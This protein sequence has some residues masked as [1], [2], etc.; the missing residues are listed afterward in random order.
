[1]RSKQEDEILH[2]GLYHSKVN[3]A[4]EHKPLGFRLTFEDDLIGIFREDIRSV[5][6]LVEGLGWKE[7]IVSLMING[8]PTMAAQDIADALETK[9]ATITTTLNR[10]KGK[11]FVALPQGKWGLL[12]TSTNR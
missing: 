7:K 8:N 3:D 6:E 4:P 2:L 1:M 9:V 10:H 11:T 5:P 12:E